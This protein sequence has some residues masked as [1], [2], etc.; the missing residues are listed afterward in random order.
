MHID[1]SWLSQ[2]SCL[3]HIPFRGW[4]STNPVH[5]V[6]NWLKIFLYFAIFLVFMGQILNPWRHSL[7]AHNSMV[8]CQKGPTRHAYAWQMGP[9][10]RIPSNYCQFG[11]SGNSPKRYHLTDIRIPIINIWRP[12]DR[13]RFMIGNPTAIRF[14]VT[15]VCRNKSGD[16]TLVHYIDD[17]W[18]SWLVKSPEAV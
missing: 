6:H 2:F 7:W 3:K 16:L 12:D 11:M 10:G 15:P 5:L 14:Q 8:S 1:F 17:S 4:L 18:A 13:L 9:F